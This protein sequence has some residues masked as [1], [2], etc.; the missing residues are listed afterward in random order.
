MLEYDS[1]EQ[2]VEADWVVSLATKRPAKTK[3]G[4]LVS[5]LAMSC[6]LDGATRN[7]TCLLRAVLQIAF[8]HRETSPRLEYSLHA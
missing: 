6:M 2:G 5:W 3:Y 7:T 4:L 8:C 1:L